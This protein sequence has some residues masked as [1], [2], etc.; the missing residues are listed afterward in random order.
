MEQQNNF[1][2]TFILF[3]A[4][5]FGPSMFILITLLLKFMKA[6]PFLAADTFSETILSA[7]AALLFVVYFLARYL[8]NKKLQQINSLNT[9]SNNWELYR[10]AMITTVALIEFVVLLNIIF[11][12][13]QAHPINLI[14]AI[15]GIFSLITFKPEK[16]KIA[17]LFGVDEYTLN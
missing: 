1:R 8:Y 13:L 5:V 7:V 9:L 10:Q 12:M 16:H 2:S 3:V 11:Y 6:V 4:M 14:I 17:T 15:A